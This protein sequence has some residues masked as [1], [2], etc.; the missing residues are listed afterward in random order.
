MSIVFKARKFQLNRSSELNK[1]GKG[2]NSRI[3]EMLGNQYFLMRKYLAASRE[4]ETA[5]QKESS[6][7][8]VLKKLII[9]Y[10]QTNRPYEALSLFCG[11]IS[12]NMESIA[13]T[14]FNTEDCPCTGLIG[15]VESGKVRYEDKFVTNCMLGILWL[16]CDIE[17]SLRYMR[18]AS[19]LNKENSLLDKIISVYESYL[20]NIPQ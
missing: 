4:L 6:N 10:T 5:L 14:A 17:I 20:K 9:C 2:L 3:N 19:K 12:Q 11:L 7:L 15:E 18:Q 13:E 1:R 8:P 16:F